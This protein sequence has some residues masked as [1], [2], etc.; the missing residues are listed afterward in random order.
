MQRAH[1]F[2]CLGLLGTVLAW[3][4]AEIGTTESAVTFTTGVNLVPVKVVVRDKQGR[5]VGNLTQDD[6]ILQD[7]GRQQTIVRFSAETPEPQKVQVV[8]EAV[9]DAGRPVLQPRE[10]RAAVIPERFLAYVFDDVHTPIG[11]LMQAREAAVKQLTEVLDPATR[12][13]V[14]STSGQT[15]LDFTDDHEIVAEV[16]REIRRYSAD[17]VSNECPPIT[18]YWANLIINNGDKMAMDAATQSVIQCEPALAYDPPSAVQMARSTAFM[19]LSQGQRETRM[20]IGIIADVARRM[21]AMPGS[22]SI[23]YVS[24]GFMV[25]QLV[26]IE[27]QRAFE[28]AVKAKVVVNALD[29]RG[30]YTGMPTAGTMLT[31]PDLVT[32]MTRLEREQAFLQSNVLGEFASATGGRFINNTNAFDEGFRRVTATPEFSYTLAFS[33]SGLKYDGSFHEL[34]VKL[35]ERPGLNVKNLEVF[36]RNGYVA[37]NALADAEETAREE[38]RDAVFG[39]DEVVDVPVDL[40]LQ[41]FKSAPT[42]AHLTVIAKVNLDGVKFRKGEER[43]NDVLT[44]V[45]VVF[46]RNGNFVKGVQ[47]VL[48]MKLRDETLEKLLD[49][50]GI[51]VR[52]QIDL[53]P[54]SYLVRLVVRDA[55]GKDMAMR[56]GAVEI[57]F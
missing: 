10:A 48:D 34:K 44:V 47:R 14:Y 3:G 11:D 20:G 36:A 42:E 8:A 25:D 40:T 32:F 55:E 38:I 30:L 22:R 26:R 31:S 23:V 35:K 57:P 7:R 50:G 24:S 6:F 15:H 4:Q 54:G 43:N 12:V 51:S 5:A 49:Q 53:P 16:M 33:P 52:T 18:Y 27:E 28:I 9:D 56:N 17:E 37:P 13:A 45:S 21:A 29:A 46:D 41:Y 19:K 1:Q 2:V 39:R